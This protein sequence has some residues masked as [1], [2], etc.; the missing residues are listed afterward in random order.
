M[1]S[2]FRFRLSQVSG[3]L[4][5]IHTY[6]AVLMPCRSAKGLD[7]ISHVIYTVR[8]GLIHT[9]HAFPLPRH[10]YAVVK[11]TSQG[12]GRFAAGERHGMCELASAVQRRYVGDLPAFGIVGEWQ[13]RGRGTAWYV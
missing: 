11:A 6:H 1:A 4:W 12:H 9:C 5:Q 8:P 10:E 7:C 3:D 2:P 13:G